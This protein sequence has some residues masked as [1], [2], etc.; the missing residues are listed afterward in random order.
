MGARGPNPN[1]EHLYLREKIWW[2]WFYDHEGR[3]VR[4]STG[5]TDKKAAR[6]RLAGWERSAADPHAAAPQS[7]NDCLQTL[8]DDRRERTGSQNV[9]Y[10][11]TKAK[12]LV[13]VFG[14][15]LLIAAFRD[16]SALPWSYV[17]AR[18]RMRGNKRSVSDRTIKRELGLLRMAL[19]LAKSRGAWSGDLD[20]IVPAD[21]RP[22]PAPKGDH[23]TREEAVRLFRHLTPDTAAATAFSLAT[24]AE[25][26]G[27]LRARRTDIP[28][29]FARCNAILVR[30]TKTAAR[31][32]LVPIVTDEQKVLLEYARRHAKGVGERLFGNLH[33]MLAELKAACLAEDVVVVST[34]D[35][36]RS[37]G[38]WMVDLGV[39][40]ELVSKFMRHANTLITETVYAS[41]R[42]EDVRGRIL[43]A[44]DPRY[45]RQARAGLQNVPVATIEAVPEPRDETVLYE[46]EGVSRTLT[47]WA[48]A[49]GIKKT[50]LHYRLVTKQMP[51]G[52]ALQQG[53]MGPRGRDPRP[54][55]ATLTTAEEESGCVT[56]VTVSVHKAGSKGPSGLSAAEGPPRKSSKLLS[57][58][59]RPAGLEP[60]TGGLEG[61][62]SIQL[63]YGRVTWLTM[64][65]VVSFR[66]VADAA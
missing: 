42:P 12:A 14:H 28:A 2:C 56:G 9:Q 65:N 3:R 7:L 51:V 22:P 30:G 26:Q 61:R 19:A 1:A 46:H 16:D 62:C 54:K 33:R 36:R 41:V 44:I 64:G 45:A 10:L 6:A 38:Q 27:L 8:L 55:K 5:A 32:G 66:S 50:T 59:A 39:P 40:L 48:Q 15:D 4:R 24:G 21:F 52:V 23:I 63:S 53:R 31:H 57:L 20:L 43:E 34:H 37:A 58:L 17:D 13:T 18:R 11:T 49:T 35:L 29:D 60:A 47:G 25:V